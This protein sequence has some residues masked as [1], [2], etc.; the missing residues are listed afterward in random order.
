MQRAGIESI[1]GVR[2]RGDTLVLDP[3]IPRAWP[4]F[5]VRLRHGTATYEIRIENPEGVAR[6]VTWATHDNV[7]LALPVEL[8]LVDDGATHHVQLRLGR[9]E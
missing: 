4:K 1:L 6:N 8:V 5:D 2:R 7:A 9:L 3:C